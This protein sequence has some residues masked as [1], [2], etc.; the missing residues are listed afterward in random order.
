MELP[1]D[2]VE[3]NDVKVLDPIFDGSLTSRRK[4]LFFFFAIK[5]EEFPPDVVILRSPQIVFTNSVR[6]L[7]I[8]CKGLDSWGNNHEL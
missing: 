1:E 6:Y 5:S 4:N 2:I 8:L 7:L 3:L